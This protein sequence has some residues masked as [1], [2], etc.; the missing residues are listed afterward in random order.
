VGL[1]GKPVLPLCHRWRASHV[2][3]VDH[4]NLQW[5]RLSSDLEAPGSFQHV[6]ALGDVLS[7]RQGL[8]S[9]ASIPT[10]AEIEVQ[11]RL[12]R[13]VD[14]DEGPAL[15]NP[16]ENFSVSVRRH[17]TYQLAYRP[18]RSTQRSADVISRRAAGDGRRSLARGLSSTLPPARPTK[19]PERE[20]KRILHPPGPQKK[21]T[22]KRKP[23]PLPQKNRGQKKTPQPCVQ[24]ASLAR[25]R[26]LCRR[27]R[28][29]LYVHGPVSRPDWESATVQRLAK[30]PTAGSASG[31][32][33]RKAGRQAAG[34]CDDRRTTSTA[35]VMGLSGAALYNQPGTRRIQ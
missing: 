34:K 18:S 25:G 8:T 1:Q 12:R 28:R 21:K 14:P 2:V 4:E 16:Q 15:A 27:A 22:K 13:E 26:S 10:R 3:F 6:T 20:K 29:T 19:R 9:T 5:L 24:V 11:P 35:R 30:P 33:A 23:P 31:F 7:R 32:S 17:S